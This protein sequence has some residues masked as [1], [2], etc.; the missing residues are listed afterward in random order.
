MFNLIISSYAGQTLRTISSS[1]RDFE[2]WPPEN[3]T[4]PEN[5][6]RAD[7]NAVHEDMTLIGIFGI[8]DPLRPT[9]ISA[10]E[11]CR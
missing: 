3:A 2:S 9:V 1:Y 10:L 6:Q 11:D 5:P 7:F 8:K 4:C